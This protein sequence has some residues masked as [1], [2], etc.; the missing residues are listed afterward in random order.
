M[1]MNQLNPNHR[2][3]HEFQVITALGFGT[4]EIK[5]FYG[6]VEDMAKEKVGSA[7]WLEPKRKDNHGTDD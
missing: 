4:Y 3:S 7:P 2:M 1:E 6:R 5:D